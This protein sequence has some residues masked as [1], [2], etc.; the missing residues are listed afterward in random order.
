MLT[1]S[2]LSLDGKMPRCCLWAACTIFEEGGIINILNSDQR[3][4]WVEG[5]RFNQLLDLMKQAKCRQRE[6][7]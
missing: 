4:V 1:D 6:S 3:S 7:V 5:H 2:I